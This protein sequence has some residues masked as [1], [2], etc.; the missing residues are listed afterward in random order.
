M[1]LP[2]RKFLHLA[3]AATALPAASRIA[4][5]QSYPTRPVHIIVGFP[6]G[7]TG[8]TVTRLLGQRLSERLGQPFVIENRPGAGSNIATEAV[9]RA[10]PDGHT[11]LCVTTANE[12]G[13]TLYKNLNFNF[14]RDIAP[15]AGFVQ[16]PLVMEVNPSV[17]AKTVLELIAYSKA[18]PGKINM[19]SAGNG[20][21]HHVAGELFNMMAGIN[22]LHVPFRGSPPALTDLMGGQV[23]LMFDLTISSI[24]YIRAGKLRGLAVTSATRPQ[25]LPDIP[26]VGEFVPGYEASAW[27][28]VGAPKDTPPEIVD[29]LNREINAG[30]TDPKIKEWLANIGAVPMPMTPAEF[31]KLISDETDKWG[32]VVTFAGIRAD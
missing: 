31:G 21:I 17:P 24:E 2:R 28:G 13:V 23:Q 29:K 30:L 25:A 19:A 22:M 1:K 9:V 18:N 10:R 6:A 27:N 7:S 3:A 15:V 14:I 4:R 26:T 20:T 16:L 12:I 8:D 11:L 32:K 5:A